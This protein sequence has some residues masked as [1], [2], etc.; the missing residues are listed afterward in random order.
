MPI[1]SRMISLPSPWSKEFSFE[2]MGSQRYRRG[3][4]LDEWGGS[5]KETPSIALYADSM[6][7]EKC[8]IMGP[9]W[10]PSIFVLVRGQL[11]ESILLRE[12]IKPSN[13]DV[14]VQYQ[15]IWRSLLVSSITEQ[16]TEGEAIIRRRPPR[17]EYWRALP[18]KLKWQCWS[19][20]ERRYAAF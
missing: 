18:V 17:L 13:H 9:L 1:R 2:D 14:R 3:G 4:L 16:A 12:G 20:G 8:R 19:W 7:E 15:T 6:Y 11:T 5:S 10:G